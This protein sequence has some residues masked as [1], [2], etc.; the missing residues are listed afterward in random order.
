MTISLYFTSNMFQGYNVHWLWS[1]L[2]G[3]SFTFTQTTWSTWFQNNSKNRRS[4]SSR[5]LLLQRSTIANHQPF[6][7][8]GPVIYYW[9]GGDWVEN[10]GSTKNF[11]GM[12][13]CASIGGLWKN[14]IAHTV[15]VPLACENADIFLWGGVYE[16]FWIHYGGLWKNFTWGGGSTKIVWL[17]FAKL[18][19][20]SPRCR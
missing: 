17:T 8:K 2:G 6:A 4:K 18:P 11:G 9:R 7:S 15:V 12:K 14:A 5:S 16:K 1:I 20:P 13:F 19:F 10:G 3:R